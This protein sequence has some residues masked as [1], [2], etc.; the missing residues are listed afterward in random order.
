MRQAVVLIVVVVVLLLDCLLY[1]FPAAFC[2]SNE[3]TN[4]PRFLLLL[5]TRHPEIYGQVDSWNELSL[6]NWKEAS[7][8]NL[9]A[10]MNV[11][12]L[13]SSFVYCKAE[14]KLRFYRKI[15][16]ENI[17]DLISEEGYSQETKKV[18]CYTLFWL[19]W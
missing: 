10:L 5:S 11:Y 14:Q 4:H 9:A 19:W 15:C 18:S 6:G 3:P 16:Y 13:S 17:I 12:F 7:V 1:A 8:I 2:I